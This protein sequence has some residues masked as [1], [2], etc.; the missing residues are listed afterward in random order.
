MFD[1]DLFRQRMD[2]L[3]KNSV[4]LVDENVVTINNKKVFFFV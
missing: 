3:K 4:P 1:F 2:A